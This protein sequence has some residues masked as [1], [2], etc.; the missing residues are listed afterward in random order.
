MVRSGYI[1]PL[2]FLYPAFMLAVGFLPVSAGTVPGLS[3]GKV[4]LARCHYDEQYSCK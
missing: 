3:P 1:L 4:G 2:S